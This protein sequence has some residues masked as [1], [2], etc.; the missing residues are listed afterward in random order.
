VVIDELDGSYNN[1]D[2][3]TEMHGVMQK[4]DQMN[5]VNNIT[6]LKNTVARGTQLLKLGEL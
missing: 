6:E 2:F 4:L 1:D 3:I 5:D